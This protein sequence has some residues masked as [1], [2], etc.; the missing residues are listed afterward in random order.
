MKQIIL[1]IGVNVL[2]I[3]YLPFKLLKTRN[4]IVYIS[5]QFN[6]STLDFTLLKNA[7]GNIDKNVENVILTKRIEKGFKNAVFYVLHIFKQMYHVATAKVVVVDTYCIVVSVLKHKKETKIIQIWH[8][9]RSYKKIWISNNRK[10]IWNRLKYSK[11]YE[12]A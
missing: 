8:A 9:L 10:T 2:K 1:T 7:I 6:N 4:K 12:N 5:R 3:V 11:N